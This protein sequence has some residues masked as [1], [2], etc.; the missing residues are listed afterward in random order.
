[1][2]D[3]RKNLKNKLMLEEADSKDKSDKSTDTT[4]SPERAKSSSTADAERTR[5]VELLGVINRRLEEARRDQNDAEA[6]LRKE[7]YKNARLE[8]KIARLELEKVGAIKNGRGSYS[9]GINKVGEMANLDDDIL[10]CTTRQDHTISRMNPHI[11][12]HVA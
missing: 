10:V 7:R 9:Q 12:I 5:L 1:M 11:C 6:Q 2:G 8:T 4:L 3:M